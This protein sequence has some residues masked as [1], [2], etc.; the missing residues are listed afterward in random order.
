MSRS[1]RWGEISRSSGKPTSEGPVSRSICQRHTP[2]LLNACPMIPMLWLAQGPPNQSGDTGLSDP[3]RAPRVSNVGS[4]FALL[5]PPNDPRH[6]LQPM[7]R[8][9]SFRVGRTL[10]KPSNASLSPPDVLYALPSD[11]DRVGRGEG[12]GARGSQGLAGTMGS[13][14]TEGL[15]RRVTMGVSLYAQVIG[16][17]GRPSPCQ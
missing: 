10:T 12:S 5:R 14:A 9:K 8:T 11:V 13:R 16:E 4:Q 7:R 15:V 1:C 2:E 6:R 3:T 17:E